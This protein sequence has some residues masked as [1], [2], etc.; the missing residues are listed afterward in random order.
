MTWTS[1]LRIL[2]SVFSAVGSLG[3][4]LVGGSW[5]GGRTY[6]E[7]QGASVTRTLGRWSR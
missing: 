1:R 2:H 7:R 4:L 5:R 6:G 3:G